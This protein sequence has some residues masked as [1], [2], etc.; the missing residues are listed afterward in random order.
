MIFPIT[1]TRTLKSSNAR[2][3]PGFVI[4]GKGIPQPAAIWSQ[5]AF[6]ARHKLNPVNLI[7]RLTSKNHRRRMEYMGHEVEVTVSARLYGQPEAQARRREAEAMARGYDGLFRGMTI[8]QLEGEM[9]A[10]SASARAWV[11]K[12]IREISRYK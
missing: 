8:V 12:H 2:N 3:W 4:L 1:I 9:Q 6:E 11:D 10:R 5:E 7:R